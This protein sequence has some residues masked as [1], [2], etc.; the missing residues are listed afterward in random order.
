MFHKTFRL[1]ALCALIATIFILPQTV[2]AAGAPDMTVQKVD[3]RDVK[4]GS[5]AGG[6]SAQDTA[7]PH[8][9]NTYTT[10]VSLDLGTGPGPG[11]WATRRTEVT[12]EIDPAAIHTRAPG[13]SFGNHRPHR[14]L[15]PH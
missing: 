13:V 5:C 11:D 15:P 10:P 12:V 1:A 14:P 9:A 2:M 7:E 6:L 8:T 3:A 4:C